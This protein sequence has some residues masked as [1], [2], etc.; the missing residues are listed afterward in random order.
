MKE[1]KETKYIFTVD[2]W[3]DR[4]VYYVISRN[5]GMKRSRIN[6]KA[7]RACYNQMNIEYMRPKQSPENETIVQFEFYS[8]DELPKG[9]E[10]KFRK[11]QKRKRVK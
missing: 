1:V 11:A 7:F 8:N 9:I 10:T 3:N 6:A 4:P 2:N 5:E